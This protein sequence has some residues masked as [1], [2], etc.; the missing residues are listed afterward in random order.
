VSF[1]GQA[2]AI[3]EGEAFRQPL[4]V[5]SAKADRDDE[6]TNVDPLIRLDQWKANQIKINREVPE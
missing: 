4:V 2:E 3:Y 6:N 1:S 5:K